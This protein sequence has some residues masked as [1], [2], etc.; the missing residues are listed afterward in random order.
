[1]A[2]ILQSSFVLILISGSKKKI[3][4][5]H[6]LNGKI[7]TFTRFLSLASSGMVCLV[8]REAFNNLINADDLPGCIFL[9][10]T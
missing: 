10:G 6:F 1:M 5:L 3:Y 4:H 8:D 2:D 9:S 7:S